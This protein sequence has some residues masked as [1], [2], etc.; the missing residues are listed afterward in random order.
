MEELEI[1]GPVELVLEG[2]PRFREPNLVLSPC[3]EGA[4]H[5]SCA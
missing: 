5:I 3:L 2:S 4:V 1:P